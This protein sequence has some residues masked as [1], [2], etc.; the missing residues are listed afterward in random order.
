MEDIILYHGS[1]GGL[2][3]AIKP[4]SRER[5]DFGQGFYMGTNPEQA[6]SLV[7]NEDYPVFYS[8]ELRL[9]EIPEERIYRPTETEWLQIVL[10]FRRQVK[11][12]SDLPVAEKMRQKL[13][14]YDV[15]IGPI[16]DD[17]M[18]D[19]MKAFTNM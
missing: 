1:R 7:C 2:Q 8:L 15:I 16:S 5:C 17:R 9:S 12:Y 14:D 4:I 3:G 18:K 19:A 6:K 10:S 11:E 13:K